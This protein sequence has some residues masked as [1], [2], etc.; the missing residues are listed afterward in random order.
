MF[1]QLINEFRIIFLETKWQNLWFFPRDWYKISQYLPDQFTNF[2]FSPRDRLT[3]FTFFSH[4]WLKHFTIYPRSTHKFRDFFWQLVNAALFSRDRLTSFMIF[5]LEPMNKF[6][7]IFSD[8]VS[9]FEIFICDRLTNFVL[10]YGIE[11]RNLCVFDAT[12]GRISWFFRTSR[13]ILWFFSWN[14]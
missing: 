1:P 4:I 6:L 14:E 9:N 2:A 11:E 12:V 8:I 10:F 5:F 3:K 7:D 13:W